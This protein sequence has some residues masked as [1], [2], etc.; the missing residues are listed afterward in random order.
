MSEENLAVEDDGTL[1]T[2]VDQTTDDEGGEDENSGI[3]DIDVSG[4]K[5]PNDPAPHGTYKLEIKRYGPKNSQAGEPMLSAQYQIVEARDS[6]QAE[7]VGKYVF[8]NMMLSGAG[9]RFGRWAHRL[10]TEAVGLPLSGGPIAAYIGK[11]FWAELQVDPGNA[12]YGPSNKIV[13]VFKES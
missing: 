13:N 4:D 10:V 2:L 3:I 5:D 6:A 11:Q 7:N 9:E 8:I 1:Q 12:Q